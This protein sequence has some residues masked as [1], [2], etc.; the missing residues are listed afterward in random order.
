MFPFQTVPLFE[1]IVD[2]VNCSPVKRHGQENDNICHTD[3]LVEIL[4]LA[5]LLGKWNDLQ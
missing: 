3:Q 5:S 1:K 2:F 4:G